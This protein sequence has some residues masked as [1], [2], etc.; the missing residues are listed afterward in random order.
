MK[1]IKDRTVRRKNE[2]G[3]PGLHRPFQPKKNKAD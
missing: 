2:S 3:V 1:S